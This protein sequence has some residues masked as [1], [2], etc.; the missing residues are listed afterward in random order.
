MSA[1]KDSWRSY[2]TGLYSIINKLRM[3][4]SISDEELE[5]LQQQIEQLEEESAYLLPG[6]YPR[7]LSGQSDRCGDN[8]AIAAKVVDSFLP[9]HATTEGVQRFVAQFG[10]N[11]VEFYRS[12][13]DILVSSVGIGTCRGASEADADAAYVGAVTAALE[14]GVNLIDTSLNYRNQRS[15]RAVGAGIRLFVANGGKRDEIVVC[16]KGGFLLPEAIA[17]G[18][19]QPND[20]VGGMHCMTPAFL[21]DQIERSRQNLTLRTIDVYYLHNPEIQL[22]YVQM[23]EFM[24]RIYAAFEH[25]EREVSNGV[26]RWY[27]TATWHGYRC[28][29]LSLRTLIDAAQRVAGD[30][31]HFRF[32]ELPF[33]LGM[34]EALVRP[35][36]PERTLLQIANELGVT[37]IASAS[38]FRSILLSTLREDITRMLPGLTSHAQRAIQL[39]RSAFGITSALVGMSDRRHVH[40]NLAVTNIAPLT[41]EEYQTI[42]SAISFDQSH[43]MRC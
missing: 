43:T 25:L 28:G 31:H 8:A 40:E 27:G 36:E 6:G 4:V 18:I 15:E 19:V 29:A 11:S 7:R 42:F 39:T 2:D 3:R 24:N 10:K 12:A 5:Q 22:K 37:V 20:V 16:T 14:G 41:P 1:S 26:I 30:G 33:N 9:G 32:I 34:Q 17:G 21:A 38:L 35:V 13:Q 23:S